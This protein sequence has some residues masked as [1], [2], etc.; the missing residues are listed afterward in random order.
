MPGSGNILI[1]AIAGVGWL[2]RNGDRNI[3][4]FFENTA[5]HSWT[6]GERDALRSALQQYANVANITIQEVGA[7]ASADLSERWVS[8]SY[9]DT[10][11]DGATAVHEFPKSSP[12]AV[13]SYNFDG[14]PY[15]TTGGIAAGGFGFTVF[16]H[17]IGHAPART[18]LTAELATTGRSIRAIC[19]AT[20]CAIWQPASRWSGR[21]ERTH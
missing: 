1:D 19:P 9:L 16:L 7:A 21:S 13:G 18:R 4:F 3:T 5:L 11:F 6:A 20:R 12:P 2:G 14:T 10:F 17:E 8:D 15:F